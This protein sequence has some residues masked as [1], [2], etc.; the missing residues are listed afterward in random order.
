MK[1]VILPRIGDVGEAVSV[2]AKILGRIEAAYPGCQ[3]GLCEKLQGDGLVSESQLPCRCESLLPELSKL[4]N[5]PIIQQ[6][7]EALL[8]VDQAIVAAGVRTHAEA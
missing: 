6:R 1:D 8:A 7:A 3:Q 5:N 2:V 4:R